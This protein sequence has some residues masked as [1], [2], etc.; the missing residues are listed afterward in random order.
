MPFAIFAG[1]GEFFQFIS[2]DGQPAIGVAETE[3]QR[4][5]K[6]LNRSESWSLP[7]NFFPIFIGQCAHRQPLSDSLLFFRVNI[8][9]VACVNSN[10]CSGIFHLLCGPSLGLPQFGPGIITRLVATVHECGQADDIEWKITLAENFA[11][12]ANQRRQQGSVLV[13]PFSIRLALI[14]D[15]AP[16]G[17]RR[18]W[19]NHAFIKNHRHRR[20]ILK[21]QRHGMRRTGVDA[22]RAFP[23]TG[24][25][26]DYLI[27]N[28]QSKALWSRQKS[29]LRFHLK[30]P[31]GENISTGLQH[32]AFDFI[33][34]GILHP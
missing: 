12:V 17:Q 32:A 24:Q 28:D 22:Q 16:D 33:R 30:N 10:D 29:A 4:S 6:M 2:L 23:F 14:P 7:G 15:D 31:H 5:R 8:V 20:I 21:G 34:P 1:N 3:F 19:L 11:P 9:R 18:H 27:A 13:R 25:R 26:D